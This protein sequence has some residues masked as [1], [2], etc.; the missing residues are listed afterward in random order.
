MLAFYH[1]RFYK[2][3]TNKNRLA[4]PHLLFD[5]CSLPSWFVWAVATQ[6]GRCGLSMSVCLSVCLSAAAASLQCDMGWTSLDLIHLLPCATSSSTVLTAAHKG[7][8]TQL[9]KSEDPVGGNAQHW[10]WCEATRSQH[11]KVW[12]QNSPPECVCWAELHCN[13]S[14]FKILQKYFKNSNLFFKITIFGGV[15]ALL[16][17]HNCVKAQM[18]HV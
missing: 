10:A 17:R 18:F 9:T 14:H 1:Q 4:S 7:V 16:F 11:R 5:N 13:L 15:A 12:P 6:R 2:K 8:K 3:Q